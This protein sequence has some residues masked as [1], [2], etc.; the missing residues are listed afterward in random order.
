MIS[1]LEKYNETL[2]DDDKIAIPKLDDFEG[3]KK[4]K[5]AHLVKK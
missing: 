2:S 5:E 1:G 4:S 3:S